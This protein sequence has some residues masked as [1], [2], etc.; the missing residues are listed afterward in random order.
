MVSVSSIRWLHPGALLAA[1]LCLA[2]CT[3]QKPA[4]A[5]APATG[6]GWRGG[7]LR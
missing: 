4:P 7:V 1:A 3:R 6:P 2:G 5:S